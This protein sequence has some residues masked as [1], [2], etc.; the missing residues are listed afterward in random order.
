MVVSGYF[1]VIRAMFTFKQLINSSGYKK[2]FLIKR[3]QINR[4]KFYMA[5]K[6]PSLLNLDELQRLASALRIDVKS[7]Q[8]IINGQTSGYD[9]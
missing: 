2:E 3:S 8:D 9:H 6:N 7:L 1:S 4:R 5:I